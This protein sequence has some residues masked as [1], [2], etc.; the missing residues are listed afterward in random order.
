MPYKPFIPKPT[1]TRQPSKLPYITEYE[2]VQTGTTDFPTVE[3]RADAGNTREA[4]RGATELAGYIPALN[5]PAQ[6]ALAAD[7]LSQGNYKGAAVNAAFAV[8]FVKP[9]AKGAKMLS[10]AGKYAKNLF[11]KSK[12]KKVSNPLNESEKAYAKDMNIKLANTREDLDNAYKSK[13]TLFRAISVNPKRLAADEKFM[14]N[15]KDHG[16]NINDEQELIK[17]YGMSS[18]GKGNNVMKEVTGGNPNVGIIYASSNRRHAADYGTRNMKKGDQ[19][20]MLEFP[21]NTTKTSKLSNVG[22]INKISNYKRNEI[23]WNQVKEMKQIGG[24]SKYPHGTSFGM[25]PTINTAMDKKFGVAD[26]VTKSTKP[27]TVQGKRP[28]RLPHEVKLIRYK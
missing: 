28:L 15:A 19:S 5:V 6:A 27:F 2:D 25:Q 20:Y 23:P 13:N 18:G 11:N 10:K 1:S 21:G 26:I 17:Y 4:V 3:S 8:P 24:L 12:A 7:D 22:L 14:K 9:I 16:I